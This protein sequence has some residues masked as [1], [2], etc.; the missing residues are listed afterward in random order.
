[1]SALLDLVS[2]IKDG[3]DRKTAVIPTR[4][5][6]LYVKIEDPKTKVLSPYSFKYHP[7]TVEMW[8]TP[9]S[10]VGP[11]AAQMGYT[12]S[13]LGRALYL[14]DVQKTS[15]LYLLPKKSPDATDFSKSRFDPIIEQSEH[16]KTIFTDVN[17]I[18]HKKA[19]SA[20]LFVRGM[21]SKSGVKSLPVGCV[22][23]DEFDEM[24]MTN[25]AQAEQRMA[26]QFEK[27]N[28]KISTPTIPNKRIDGEYNRSTKEHY[29]FRCPRC[30]K[31]TEFD[32]PEALV[33][34]TDDPSDDQAL[35]KS[36]YRCPECKGPIYHEEKAGFLS[37]DKSLWYPTQ[38]SHSDVRG[39][40]INQFYSF[41]EKPSVIGKL[42]LL[43]R[44]DPE[45]EQEFWNSAGGMA[46]IPEGSRISETHIL[47]DVEHE[48][49]TRIASERWESTSGRRFTT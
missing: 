40:H 11:K 15:V 48:H 20:S 14:I 4:W 5:A 28:I 17:N 25:V 3:L 39:F 29:F 10:W 44:D 33:I 2:V 46:R 8:N 36:H 45:K 27:Q 18:G 1:M 23:F 13:A 26:G 41:T 37:V 34:Y 43:A 38:K 24:P 9:K 22:I 31:W 49:P 6:N 42:A 7:W 32:F 19:G 16:L 12:Q 30:G 35:A 47:T 21:R